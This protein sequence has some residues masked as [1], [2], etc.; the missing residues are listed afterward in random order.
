MWRRAYKHARSADRKHT[1]KDGVGGCSVFAMGTCSRSGFNH[2][3]MTGRLNYHAAGVTLGCLEKRR[4]MFN[5]VEVLE[6]PCSR[7]NQQNYRSRNARAVLP[8]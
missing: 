6:L 4:I 8:C 5:E 3:I 1:G 2:I 7:M